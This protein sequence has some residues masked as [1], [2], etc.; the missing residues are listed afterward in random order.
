M[1]VGKHDAIIS[2]K[3]QFVEK[4]YYIVEGKGKRWF[5]EM[6]VDI[7]IGGTI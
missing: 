5:L 1:S 2:D 4:I 3:K 6:A 7:M